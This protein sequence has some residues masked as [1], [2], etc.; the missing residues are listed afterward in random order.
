MKK[1]QTICKLF[2]LIVVLSVT[3]LFLPKTTTSQAATIKLNYSKLTLKCGESKALTLGGITKDIIWSSSN[4]SIV[5]VSKSGKVTAVKAGK[6]NITAT[7][8][9][10]IY[11]CK[12]TVKAVDYLKD[13]PFEADEVKLAGLHFVLPNS[14][15]Y[16]TYDTNG[17]NGSLQANSKSADTS[18]KYSYI[19]LSITNTGTPKPD[20]KTNK[21]SL[22]D[23]LTQKSVLSQFKQAGKK[24]TVTK[25]L[26][27]DIE[28]S[29]GTA[30]KTEY[31]L[32]IDGK[33]EHHSLYDLCIDNYKISLFI[34][35]AYDNT[36]PDVTTVGE[37][38]LKSLHYEK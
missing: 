20:Y 26:Q 13:A 16:F 22:A 11:S 30:L 12:I 33:S 1:L 29:L 32:K 15:D 18:D 35:D 28:T 23:S 8:N 2:V 19:N 5:T 34:V 17:S 24:V 31:I 4:K 38:L 36:K 6:A 37:Y 9:K 25:F 14:Y 3:A 10:K 7:L 27:S 21:K